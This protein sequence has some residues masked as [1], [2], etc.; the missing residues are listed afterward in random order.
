MLKF[1]KRLKKSEVGPDV[2]RVWNQRITK[3]LEKFVEICDKNNLRYYMLGGSLI[4]VVRHKGMIP[5]DDDID[6]GMPLPDYQRFIEICK[7][8]N[9]DDFELFTPEDTPG[10]YAS[11]ILL[12]DKNSSLLFWRRHLCVLGLFLD[13]F[14]ICGI[15]NDLEKA[16]NVY[17]KVCRYSYYLMI[18]SSKY[19][20]SN[21]LSFYN[22]NQKKRVFYY[23]LFI[24]NRSYFRKRI[25][26]K[27]KNAQLAYDYDKSD[28]LVNYVFAGGEKEIFLSKY[29][30]ETIDGDFDGVKVKIP[31]L[32]DDYLKYRY[33]DYMQLPPIEERDDRHEFDYLNL[34]KRLSREEI[35]EIIKKEGR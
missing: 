7:K 11:N 15:G 20:L 32:Y 33:G 21:L 31:Q 16:K 6:V 35:L 19:T 24:L 30:N 1:D 26:K 3:I 8:E 18:V 34:Q 5:W 9:L 4:G 23:L 22:N 28:Y 10:F 14:P 13:I 25:L 17:H 2:S 27:I 29:V 12:V